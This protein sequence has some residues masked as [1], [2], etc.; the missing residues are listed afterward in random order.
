MARAGQRPGLGFLQGTP[1]PES[2]MGIKRSLTPGLAWHAGCL[3]QLP[4]GGND[5]GDKGGDVYVAE[6][7]DHPCFAK[8][9]ADY[10]NVQAEIVQKRS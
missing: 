7:A 6:K 2:E 4:G 5:G 10:Q 9:C 1:C 3:P 8:D